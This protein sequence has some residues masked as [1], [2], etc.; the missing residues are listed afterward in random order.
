MTNGMEKGVRLF[1][2]GKAMEMRLTNSRGGSL[3]IV[4]ISVCF[5]F[6][7]KCRFFQTILFEI[8]LCFLDFCFENQYN[9]TVS[10]F[11]F[12][13]RR[14]SFRCSGTFFHTLES[15]RGVTVMSCRYSNAKYM[16]IADIIAR[17]LRAGDFLADGQF[18][19]RD[20]L[21][22]AYHISP[23]TAR[24]VLRVLEDRGIIACRKGKRPVPASVSAEQDVPSV[25]RPVFCR[26]TCT[27]ET[28]EYDFLTYCVR[29]LLLR[30]ESGL[31]EFNCDYAEEGVAPK[32]SA[33]NV[34]V[35]FPSAATGMDPT[36]K[37][38]PPDCG[39]GRIDLLINQA[40]NNAV[41][42]FTRKAMLDCILHLIRHGIT[43]VVHVVSAHSAFP[44]YAHIAAPGIL[45]EYSPGCRTSTLLFKDE[46]EMFPSFLAESVRFGT[47]PGHPAVAVLIDDPYLSDYLSGE[48]RTGTCHPP[49]WCSFFGT[50]FNERSIVFPY[51]DL[52]LD[53]LAAAILQ[54]VCAKGENPSACLACLFHLIQFRIPGVC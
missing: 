54:A 37:A 44:W 40:G 47:V 8:Y 13:P 22:R 23:G 7:Y 38:A 19:S 33:E 46:L 1:M 45:A 11:S 15:Q 51:L 24:S 14:H 42:I 18:Y 6:S 10:P 52:R 50:A 36:P 20:E 16:T 48:I 5:T 29:N 4:V 30:R 34:A 25:C 39:G 41:S 28:P 35:V 3:K 9:I 2:S 31:R 17:R 49:S 12:A 27:A 43:D 53:A 26:D 21:A 32:L